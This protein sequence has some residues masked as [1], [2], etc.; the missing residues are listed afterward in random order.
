MC[1]SKHEHDD[2]FVDLQNTKEHYNKGIR[3]EEAR[4]PN[5]PIRDL[6]KTPHN[7]FTSLQSLQSQSEEGFCPQK[8]TREN[9][10][11]APT[12]QPTATEKNRQDTPSTSLSFDKIG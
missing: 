10:F 5:M 12:N 9:T 8:I 7:F 2:H 1:S 4:N 11:F 3:K 6:I